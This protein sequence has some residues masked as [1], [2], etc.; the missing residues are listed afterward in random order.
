MGVTDRHADLRRQFG[1]PLAACALLEPQPNPVLM[2]F[3]VSPFSAPA[4]TFLASETLG[5]VDDGVDAKIS[6][7]GHMIV[8]RMGGL[9]RPGQTLLCVEI[10]RASRARARVETALRETD[11]ERATLL[12]VAGTPR[13]VDAVSWL[14]GVMQAGKGHQ[15]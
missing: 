5:E 8:E 4:K 9:M 2:I 14:L 1:E 6:P 12:F 7:V 10:K 13:L 15:P 3:H 11:P